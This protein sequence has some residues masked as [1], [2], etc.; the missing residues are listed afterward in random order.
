[1]QVILK[2][3]QRKKQNHK[4][5]ES[6]GTSTTTT[7]TVERTWTDIEPREFSIS[8]F[9][10][11]KKLINLLRH[12]SSLRDTDGAIEF[13]RIKIILR[14]I[15]CTVIIGLKTSGRAA[16]Q[17]KEDTRK[18]FSIILLHQ[19]Q[20]CTSELFKVIQNAIF[21]MLCHMTMYNSER[22]LQIHSSR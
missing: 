5:R 21:M 2:A 15:S 19:E 16:W 3:D 7:P 9:E 20:S 12:G 8:D 6:V 4:R 1:M 13:W 11:S 17:E 10:V 22:F 18:D 14:N